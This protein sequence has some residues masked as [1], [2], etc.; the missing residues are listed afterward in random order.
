[1]AASD[2]I[3]VLIGAGLLAEGAARQQI[4]SLVA[5]RRV[6]FP[7]VQYVWLIALLLVVHL[8]VGSLLKSGQRLE[9]FALPLLVGA[10]I[11][12]RGRHMIVL[13]A[14]VLAATLLAIVW[15]ILNA[16]GLAGQFQKN[17][18]GGFIASAILLVIAVRE[19][20]RLWWC[21]PL[22]LVG[23]GLTASRGAILALVVGVVVI[24]LMQ[25]GA[26]RR[27]IM[28]ARILA[29]VVTALVVY[30]FLPANIAS[31]LTNYIPS[32]S[33]RSSYA[34]YIREAYDHDA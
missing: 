13:R 26:S 33:S 17:P 12:L 24:F 19:L 9:L 25:A 15:P 1:V 34:L 10:F 31:R 5:L 4:P 20:R 7:V 6:R 30:Q 32:T 29:L 21:A 8:S 16:H 14:Y 11:A 18:T 27:A 2:V 3:M 22:L 28:V 23:A